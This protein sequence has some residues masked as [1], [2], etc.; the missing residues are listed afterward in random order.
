MAQ[1]LEHMV[2]IGG[3]FLLYIETEI[4][5]LLP[6]S[7]V[8]K[9]AGGLQYLFVLHLHH[10]GRTQQRRLS[11][12]LLPEM[13]DFTSNT[14]ALWIHCLGSFRWL[15]LPSLPSWGCIL[16]TFYSFYE[17]QDSIKWYKMDRT[18]WVS[19]HFHQPFFWGGG[20]EGET[21]FCCITLA[22]LELTL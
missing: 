17:I 19:H 13:F 22:V 15:P 10:T 20:G 14:S 7:H 18:W 5:S 16:R 1:T 2:I 4:N 9:A 6:R 8:T 12:V 3:R 21:G 11:P